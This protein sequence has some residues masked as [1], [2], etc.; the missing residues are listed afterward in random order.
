[1]SAPE[2]TKQTD[3]KS[4]AMEGDLPADNMYPTSDGPMNPPTFPIVLMKPMDAAAADSPMVIVGNTQNGGDHAHNIMP[5]MLSQIMVT[6]KGCPGM[7]IIANDNPAI[8]RG[9]AVCSL[10]SRSLSDDRAV[11]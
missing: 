3:R 8:I 9:I 5:V 7:V 4:T 11:S 2:A 6:T 10:R 1:M